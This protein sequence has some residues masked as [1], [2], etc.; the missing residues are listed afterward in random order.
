MKT[1]VYGIDAELKEQEHKK[2]GQMMDFIEEKGYIITRIL[3]DSEDITTYSEK[4]IEKIK[5]INHLEI[6]AREPKDLIFDSLKEAEKYLPRLIKG[7]DEIIINF[8]LGEELMGYELLE[9]ALEGF[10]WLNS[11]INGFINNFDLEKLEVQDTD[12][13]EIIS[14]WRD[15]LDKLLD[16]FE[17]REINLL[18]KQLKHNFKPILKEWLELITMFNKQLNNLE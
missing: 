8:N 1:T 16:A 3:A 14:K 2:L 10:Q 5:P 4:E 17:N 9:D 18:S 15:S 7:L 11:L 6:V 13:D 12:L